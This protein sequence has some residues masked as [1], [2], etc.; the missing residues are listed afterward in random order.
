MPLS[1]EL[2]APG[3]AAKPTSVLVTLCAVRHNDVSVVDHEWEAKYFTSSALTST[4]D[5]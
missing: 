2:R 4:I 3:A 5:R 1:K